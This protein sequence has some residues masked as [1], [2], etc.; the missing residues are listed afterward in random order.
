MTD[1]PAELR[2]PAFLLKTIAVF[3]NLIDSKAI[4]EHGRATREGFVRFV[5]R[6]RSETP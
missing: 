2:L 6:I 3:E 4:D 5:E 1:L